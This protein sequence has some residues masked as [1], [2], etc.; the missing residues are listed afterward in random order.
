MLQTALSGYYTPKPLFFSHLMKIQCFFSAIIFN[1]RKLRVSFQSQTR[2]FHLIPQTYTHI[3]AHVVPS[4]TLHHYQRKAVCFLI[5]QKRL[6][7]R[8]EK[9]K[10]MQQ[11]YLHPVAGSVLIHRVFL[12]VDLGLRQKGGKKRKEKIQKKITVA[13]EKSK[14][15]N[16]KEQKTRNQ[17]EVIVLILFKRW[18]KEKQRQRTKSIINTE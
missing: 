14:I 16:K 2:K 5:C 11:K 4:Y 9:R 3:Y 10:N 18:Q 17:Q 8:Q 13:R 15:E 6:K 12:W 1:F 7:K